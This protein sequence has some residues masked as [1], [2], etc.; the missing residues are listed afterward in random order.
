MIPD[1]GCT[2]LM[3]ETSTVL[4]QVKIDA[5]LAWIGSSEERENGTTC[6]STECTI[7]EKSRIPKV[8]ATRVQ[9]QNGSEMLFMDFMNGWSILTV[10]FITAKSR[11]TAA[12]PTNTGTHPVKNLNQ[13]H[14]LHHQHRLQNLSPNPNQYTVMLLVYTSTE[15]MV[16]GDVVRISPKLLLGSLLTMRN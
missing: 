6:G 3:M 5:N 15:K 14:L 16:A 7:L 10:T 1:A 2:L 13:R 9:S 4:M 11:H 8:L 12:W